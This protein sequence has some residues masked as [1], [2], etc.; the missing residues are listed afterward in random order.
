MLNH[1]KT[2]GKYLDQPLVVGKFSKVVPGVLLGG[3]TLY[4]ANEVRK[5]PKDKKKEVVINTG[6]VL[7][8]TSLAALAAP[9]IA[10][11][12]VRK[13]Y[14]KIDINKIKQFNNDLVENFLSQ[15]TVDS[16]VHKVLEK[17]KSK[18][19]NI[20]EIGLLRKKLEPTENGKKFL[21][22]FVPEPQNVTAGE[23]V[24][25]MG[26]LSVLGAIPVAGGIAG[27]I[28]GDVV[29][30][31]KTW[32]QKVPNKIKEGVYQYLANIFLCNVGAAGA[33]GI[34]ESLNVK[35]KAARAT[36]MVG[37]IILTGVIGGSSIANYISRKFIN[38]LFESKETR[39]MNKLKHQQE[40]LEK[41]NHK[42]VKSDDRKPELLDI[43]LHTD[44][45][46]TVAV[47][48][49]LKWIE[50]ALPILY[51][52]SGYR[53][54]IGYRNGDDKVKCHHHHKNK[55]YEHDKKEL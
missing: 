4:T 33:L 3:A 14:E 44:D 38:P 50:P 32:K 10:S 22:A 17:A 23:I 40:K 7:G 49:G 11:K 13:P 9:R 31:K 41:H 12:V 52:I 42:K 1:I 19:L 36:S 48:S 2:V 26:R 53:A 6:M 15:N 27:G 5:S 25:D 24:Q 30:D 47:M 20:K 37:G 54:G 55:D 29:T 46:A 18:V 28:A 34:M 51:A 21:D 45:I 39:Q 35:S 8:A 43:C 16:N